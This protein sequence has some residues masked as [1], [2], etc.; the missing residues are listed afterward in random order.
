MMCVLAERQN[1]SY[2]NYIAAGKEAA[3]GGGRQAGTEAERGGRK[4]IHQL[5][6]CVNYPHIQVLTSRYLL[7][8]YK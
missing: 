1:A 6:Q 8:T 3:G 7:S 5:L 4:E 2:N